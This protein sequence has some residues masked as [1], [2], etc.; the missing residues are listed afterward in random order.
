VIKVGISTNFYIS[1][2]VGC[3]EA[4]YACGIDDFKPWLCLLS[5]I[6]EEFVWV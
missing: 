5:L 6:E 3:V 1:K 4:K 2:M